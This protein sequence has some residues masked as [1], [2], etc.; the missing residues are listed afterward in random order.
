MTKSM[1]DDKF[2]MNYAIRAIIVW[3]QV[4]FNFTQKA[5]TRNALKANIEMHF[6]LVISYQEL[7]GK[8]KMN[9]GH[10]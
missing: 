1:H 8:K 5:F 10:F 6:M 3:F 2:H 7:T 4:P 9:I